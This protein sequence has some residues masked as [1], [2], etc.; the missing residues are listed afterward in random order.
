[1]TR[2]L[3]EYL[4]LINKV[5]K[6]IKKQYPGLSMEECLILASQRW[7][8]QYEDDVEEDQFED[9]E[10]GDEYDDDDDSGSDFESSEEEF[11]V[12]DKDL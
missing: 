6:D 10:G 1:M 2:E 3:D 8:K 7:A 12:L 9:T 11:P 5:A 4:Q